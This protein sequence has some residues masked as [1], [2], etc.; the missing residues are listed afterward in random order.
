[1]KLT[2]KAMILFDPEE[3]YQVEKIAKKQGVSV[4]ALVREAVK[5]TIL[6]RE[7]TKKEFKMK[8]AQR[9]VQAEEEI[10]EWEEI[11]KIIEKGH[12]R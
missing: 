9:F 10:P 11:E 2:K 4:G 1:M 5:K 7:D 12:L 8:A 6:S 3:Y